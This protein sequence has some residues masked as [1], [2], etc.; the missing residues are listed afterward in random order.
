MRASLIALT[1]LVAASILAGLWTV[2]G[3]V[4]ARSDRR[5]AIRLDDL[6]ILHWHLRCLLRTGHS[7]DASAPDCPSRPRDRDPFTDQLYR[8]ELQS[9]SDLVLCAEFEN[10]IPLPAWANAQ[11]S[12]DAPG[13]LQFQQVR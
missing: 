11:I 1:L 6:H 5:D 7:I 8:I 2:G 13:C 10:D 12:S 3:P 4:Q 9:G